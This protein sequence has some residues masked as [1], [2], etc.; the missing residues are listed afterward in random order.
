VTEDEAAG[1]DY[2]GFTGAEIRAAFFD[3]L[4]AAFEEEGEPTDLHIA[5]ALTDF[6]PLSK[7]MAEQIQGLRSWSK[8][9]ARLATSGGILNR[10]L[11]FA[12]IAFAPIPHITRDDVAAQAGFSEAGLC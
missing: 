12:L 7:L 11:Q 9:R 5:T 1:E 10:V 8:G 4:F 6:V 3:A 2:E